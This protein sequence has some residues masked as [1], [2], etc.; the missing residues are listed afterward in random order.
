MVYVCSVGFCEGS[1]GFCNSTSQSIFR[2]KSYAEEQTKSAMT[3]PAVDLELLV[4][5]R[6]LE[7][8]G[9]CTRC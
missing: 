1:S 6:L 8:R 5:D 3:Y 7:R 9:L 2:R 4:R